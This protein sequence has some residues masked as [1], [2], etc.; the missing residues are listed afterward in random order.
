MAKKKKHRKKSKGKAAKL[1]QKNTAQLVDG[2][3]SK[4]SAKKSGASELSNSSRPSS[5]SKSSVAQTKPTV[6][7][8]GLNQDVKADV[9]LSLSLIGVIVAAYTVLWL[10]LQYSSFGKFIYQI[11]K[12]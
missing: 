7:T 11:I 3:K 10:I 1:Q 5:R 12:L 4:Q 8:I 2:A 9:R 6:E